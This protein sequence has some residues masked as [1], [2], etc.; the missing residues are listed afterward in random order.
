MLVIGKGALTRDGPGPDVE[1]VRRGLK[2]IVF[3][4]TAKVLEERFGFR[5]AE[6]GL[7]QVFPRVPGHPLLMGLEEEHLRDWRGN[8]TIMPPRLQYTLRPRYGPTVRWCG[9]EVPRAWRCGCRGNVASVLIEKP[10][11]GD[12]L[13]IVEGGFGLGS[14]PGC[15]AGMGRSLSFLPV[16]SVTPLQKPGYENVPCWV[17]FAFSTFCEIAH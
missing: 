5:I 17:H 9:I 13:S 1:R 16:V 10:A 6:Y 2:V 4:Q 8:A 7:R 12:F 3:E 11:R 15:A 14:L